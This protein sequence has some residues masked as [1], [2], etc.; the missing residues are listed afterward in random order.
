ME[1]PPAMHGDGGHV[2]HSVAFCNCKSRKKARISAKMVLRRDDSAQFGL[3]NAASAAEL[4]GGA[5]R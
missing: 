4:T 5:H 3:T 1:S 2:V